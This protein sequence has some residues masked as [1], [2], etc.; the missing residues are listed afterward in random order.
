MIL[1]IVKAFVI[2][3]IIISFILSCAD[4]PG[5]KDFVEIP[6]EENNNTTC[7][8]L[9]REIVLFFLKDKNNVG[10]RVFPFSVGRDYYSW[11]TLGGK[12]FITDIDLTFEKSFTSEYL[13]IDDFNGDPIVSVFDIREGSIGHIEW[14]S[15]KN[16]VPVMG[17]SVFTSKSEDKFYKS[18]TLRYRYS[19]EKILAEES[20]LKI[21]LKLQ[22]CG[23]FA[24]LSPVMWDKL[25]MD[26]WR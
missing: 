25:R 12:I 10:Q 1:K 24:N 3:I 4:L 16:L 23:D 26:F 9:E 7:K 14:D 20:T 18:L 2:F 13:F 22:A 17:G 5:N 6:P 19:N 21:N 15:K 8:N 11:E